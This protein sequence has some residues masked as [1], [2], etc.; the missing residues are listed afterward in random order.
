MVEAIQH[1]GAGLVWVSHTH[2]VNT[3]EIIQWHRELAQ[4]LP[5]NVRVIIGGGAL[6]PSI[7]R[8]LPAHTYYES[9]AELMEGEASRGS[10]GHVAAPHFEMGCRPLLRSI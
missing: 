5:A 1:L 9:I 7:R 6:S 8:Q 10:R 2:I 4:Q 3:G